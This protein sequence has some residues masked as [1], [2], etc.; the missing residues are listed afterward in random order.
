MSAI[1]SIEM[2][3]EHGE[4][5]ETGNLPIFLFKYHPFSKDL[6]MGVFSHVCIVTF[7]AC[8]DAPYNAREG[9][10]TVVWGF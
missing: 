6:E 3:K 10:F 9:P 2:R 4:R 7:L 5:K 8:F 1:S